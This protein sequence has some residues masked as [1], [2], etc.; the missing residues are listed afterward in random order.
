MG[1]YYDKDNLEIRSYAGE[2]DNQHTREGNHLD[3]SRTGE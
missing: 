1:T 3:S 2:S